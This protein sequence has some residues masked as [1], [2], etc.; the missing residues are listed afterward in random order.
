MPRR[1]PLFHGT[2]ANCSSE[3]CGRE[4]A[5]RP[6]DPEA[7]P[8]PPTPFDAGAADDR[9]K[10]DQGQEE[11]ASTEDREERVDVPEEDDGAPGAL[12]SGLRAVDPPV[13]VEP[14]PQQSL[15][16]EIQGARRAGHRTGVTLYG[17]DAEAGQPVVASRPGCCRTPT[18]A[19][20]RTGQP[21]SGSGDPW[22]LICHVV[23]AVMSVVDPPTEADT[24][25]GP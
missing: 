21:S 14:R 24:S 3:L 16:A 13:E 25:H 22:S 7:D 12:V 5:D 17:L 1:N 19:G 10:R 9:E 15:R 2:T 20:S 8:Q 18:R 4:P 23:M 6:E 11:G